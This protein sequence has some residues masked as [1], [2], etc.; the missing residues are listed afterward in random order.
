MRRATA[1]SA[2]DAPIGEVFAFLSDLRHHWRLAGRWI[3]VTGLTNGQ[4]L[5]DGATIR[6]RGPL[7]M[8]FAV[9]TSVEELRPPHAIIGAGACGRSRGEVTWRL[10]DAGPRGTDVSVEVVLR[11]AAIHHWAVWLAGGRAW[12]T[13]RLAQTVGDLDAHLLA[14]ASVAV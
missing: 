8:A 9:R 12:L 5:A 1:S 7:G 2:V 11:R 13:R 3:E 10:R 14:H 4:A 6:L